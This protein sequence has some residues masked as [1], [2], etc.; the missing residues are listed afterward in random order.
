MLRV[1]SK[2]VRLEKQVHIKLNEF[3]NQ[4]TYLYNCAL[5]KRMVSQRKLGGEY[6]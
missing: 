4:L 6:T 2:T 5:Q 3:L 1:I